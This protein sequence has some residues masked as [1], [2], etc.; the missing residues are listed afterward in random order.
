MPHRQN[1]GSH[2]PWLVIGGFSHLGLHLCIVHDGCSACLASCSRE[3]AQ[4]G[5]TILDFANTCFDVVKR[6][7]AHLVFQAGEV[8]D[9]GIIITAHKGGFRVLGVLGCGSVYVRLV[10]SLAKS[11][12][13][14]RPCQG[15][16]SRATSDIGTSCGRTQKGRSHL[17]SVQEAESRILGMR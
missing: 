4:G 16:S 9:C 2:T 15:I 8:H 5:P 3:L 14:M 11:P 6:E 17:A 7:I 12:T 10:R 13:C 1:Q